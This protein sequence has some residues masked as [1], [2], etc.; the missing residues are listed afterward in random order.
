MTK[1]HDFLFIKKEVEKRGFNLLENKYIDA[2]AKMEVKCKNGHVTIK[3]W[4]KIRS[5]RGCQKC[6]GNFKKSFNDVKEIFE[7]EG[8]KVLSNDYKGVFE[9][10]NVVCDKGHNLWLSLDKFKNKKVRCAICYRENNRGENHPNWNSELT[11]EERL[12]N[13]D[14]TE[15]REWRKLV[16]EKDDFTCQRCNKKGGKINAHHIENY[17]T[18]IE[19]RF[20]ISN[21]ITFCEECHVEFHKKYGKYNNTKKQVDQFIK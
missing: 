7:K 5:G 17:S 2:K 11:D 4:D 14:T 1:K 6:A 15:N 13:R 12:I 19:K 10:L 8:Y 16:F 21:G 18:A 20:E 9:K 3:S